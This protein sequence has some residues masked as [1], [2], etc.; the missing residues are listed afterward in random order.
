MWTSLWYT[1]VFTAFIYIVSNFIPQT[2]PTALPKHHIKSACY[3][4]ILLLLT[5]LRAG[6]N[7]WRHITPLLALGTHHWAGQMSPPGSVPALSCE[8]YTDPW[9]GTSLTSVW[10][11]TVLLLLKMTFHCFFMEKSERFFFTNFP[12]YYP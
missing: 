2:S 10:V 7:F 6:M 8:P 1:S 5:D 12:Q 9:M 4:H 3:Y 11:C